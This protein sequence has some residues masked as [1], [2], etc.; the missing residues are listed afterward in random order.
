M[1]K[2]VCNICGYVYDPADGDPDN[3]VNPGT[4]FEDVP[5]DWVCPVCGAP[6]SEFSKEG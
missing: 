4:K 3:G 2:Y 5:A 1:D 6:K